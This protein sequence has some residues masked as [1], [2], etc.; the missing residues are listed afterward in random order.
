M[1][2]NEQHKRITFLH[3]MVSA[4]VFRYRN[5]DRDSQVLSM[6]EQLKE[7]TARNDGAFFYYYAQRWIYTDSMTFAW[8][9]EAPLEFKNLERW[10]DMM[11]KG[12]DPVEC[13]DFY[14]KNISNPVNNAWQNAL[15]QAHTIWKP[16]SEKSTDD[17]GDE[18]KN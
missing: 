11:Q 13:Y 9:K 2:A 3:D 15:E 8:H 5:V 7:Q 4:D 12:K 1:S 6:S 18:E 17:E 16:P 10:W 14:I